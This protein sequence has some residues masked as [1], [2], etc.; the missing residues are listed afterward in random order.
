MIKFNLG[1]RY[2]E[3]W[4]LMVLGR[5]NLGYEYTITN[6]DEL[7]AIWEYCN[8]NNIVA[9]FIRED[10]NRTVTYDMTEI[11]AALENN[12]TVFGI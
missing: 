7:E 2:N 8:K 12:I 11:G 4:V 10:T 3:E 5:I 1:K 6:T 9:E